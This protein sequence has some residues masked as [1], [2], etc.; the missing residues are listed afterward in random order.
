MGKL[1]QLIAVAQGKK[2][3]GTQVIT[4]AYQVAQKP[5]LFDG[6]SRSYT[7][8]D[9]EGDTI[10]SEHKK[11][12]H[13]VEDLLSYAQDAMRDI[14]D[15]PYSIDVANTTASADL[16]ADGEVLAKAVPVTT[17]MYLEKRVIELR[18]FVGTLPVLPIDDDWH[19]SDDRN[20]Y[21]S[22]PVETNRTKKVPRNHVLAEATDKHP[23]QV[24]VYNEDV[25]VGTWKVVKFSGAIPAKEREDMLKRCELLLDAVRTAREQANGNEAKHLKIADALTGFVFHGDGQSTGVQTKTKA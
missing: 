20:C 19:W 23:A 13:R 25:K 22:Q 2:K 17:L 7:P 21:S 8:L 9:E 3:H 5:A 6:M 1:N 14:L 10:P 15:L 11:L 18:T 4:D 24:Q 12:Q 16:V